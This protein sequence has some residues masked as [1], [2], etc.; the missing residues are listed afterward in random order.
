MNDG[1]ARIHGTDIR[2]AEVESLLTFVLADQ[3][4]GISVEIVSEII[5]PQKTT[6]VPC[7]DA[8]AP[9][10]INVRGS[11]VPVIDLRHRLGMKPGEGRHTSRMLVLDQMLDGKPAKLAVMADEV[12][13]VI[14][15]TVNEIAQVP[16]LGI[17]WP[18]ECFRGVAKLGEA[19]VILVNAENAFAI[20]A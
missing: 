8:L 4:F 15:V 18:A 12:K 5:D 2:N 7:A 17:E 16:Q 6:R 19:L 20:A 13:D 11:I 3:T 1:N 10:L 14:D 9:T